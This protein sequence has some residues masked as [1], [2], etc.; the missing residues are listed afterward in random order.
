VVLGTKLSPTGSIAGDV[1]A[2]GVGTI[3]VGAAMRAVKKRRDDGD[4]APSA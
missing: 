3:A 1:A 4:A 2:L